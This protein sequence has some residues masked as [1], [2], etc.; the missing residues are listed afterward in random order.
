MLSKIERNERRMKRE[1]ITVL[2]H[3]YQS[4]AKELMARW[5]AGQVYDLV[6]DEESA[7]RAIELAEENVRYEKQ[8]RQNV[9]PGSQYSPIY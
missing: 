3:M 5:L 6:K 4:D 1:L 8:K 7:L 9:A 2:A